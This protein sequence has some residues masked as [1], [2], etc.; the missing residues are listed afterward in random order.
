M[1]LADGIAV[2]NDIAQAAARTDAILLAVPAQELRSVAIAAERRGAVGHA[3]DRLRQGHRARHPQIHDRGDRGMRAD[4]A[5]GDPVRPELCRRRGARPA[6]R[7]D[8]RGEGPR[9]GRAARAGA[10]LGTFRPYHST[11][12]RGV[13]IGGAAKNV[14]AIAAGIVTGRGLGASAAAALTTRG[15]AEL[16]RFGRAF[17]A[18]P[19]DADR[20]VRPRRP[21]PD[22]LQPAVAQFL[23]RHRARPR[24]TA[25]RRRSHGKLAEGA[26]TAPAL[27]ELAKAQERRHADRRRR[28]RG[29]RRQAERRR[30]DRVAADAAVQ[31]GGVRW[32]T[33]W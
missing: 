13:E 24:R 2:T 16:F 28:R 25:G 5:A 9:P 6:D 11:D 27:V 12:V 22:L 29:A 8:A 15:F 18:Q 33:G 7:G 23:A 3:G 26:F 14:L 20:P 4:R 1:K 32:R 31:S 10:R 19:G 30:G 21:G 17:G